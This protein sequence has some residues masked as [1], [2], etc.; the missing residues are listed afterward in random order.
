MTYEDFAKEQRAKDMKRLMELERKGNIAY[1]KGLIDIVTYSGVTVPLGL[2]E[3]RMYVV[4]VPNATVESLAA[5]L[6]Y[7][8][9]EC[10]WLYSYPGYGE[11][12]TPVS[13]LIQQNRRVLNDLRKHL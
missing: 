2:Y 12:A 4:N 3:A 5:G 11:Y 1:N 9:T 10:E 6:D 7:S 8:D 13:V